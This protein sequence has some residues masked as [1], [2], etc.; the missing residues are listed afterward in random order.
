MAGNGLKILI[1]AGRLNRQD[2]GWP[3]R[4]FLDRLRS[5]GCHVQILCVNNGR[6]LLK[7]PQTFELPALENHWL[8]GFA[9]RGFLANDRLER[10]DL[11]HVVD[12]EM[13]GVALD[14]SETAQIPYIQTVSRF[15]T[16]GRG[17]RLS[18]RWCRK[19]IA[20]SSD[21]AHELVAQLGVPRERIE[22]IPPGV[23]PPIART[24]TSGNGNGNGKVPVIGTGGHLEEASGTGIFLEAARLVVDAGYDVEFVIA[25]QGNQQAVL[26]QRTQRPQDR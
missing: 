19:L 7:D 12:D 5:R 26:R 25:S 15:E 3:L 20:T 24:R 6:D 23:A 17:L 13:G 16:A 2:G 18:R 8:R 14:L 1:V 22:V 11:L 21:L 9:I 10:P 4:T